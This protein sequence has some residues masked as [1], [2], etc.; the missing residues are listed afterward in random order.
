M[1][2]CTGCPFSVR[3][4]EI[5]SQTVCL[6]KCM[7]LKTKTNYFFL[8][9]IHF[10]ICMRFTYELCKQQTILVRYVNRDIWSGCTTDLSIPVRIKSVLLKMSIFSMKT[11]VHQASH[12]SADLAIPRSRTRWKLI[13]FP[14]IST[15][16]HYH[17]TPP[18]VTEI[19]FYRTY[20]RKT[21]IHQ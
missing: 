8:R 9:Y 12:W 2:R 4:K 17:P 3:G 19:L 14:N 7:V 15:A 1:D 6:Q 11:G 5:I 16:F 10:C 21:S 13:F 18:D 20:K